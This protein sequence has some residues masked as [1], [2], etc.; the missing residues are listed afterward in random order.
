MSN[1]D[2]SPYRLAFQDFDRARRERFFEA[3]DYLNGL[4]LAATKGRESYRRFNEEA[5]DQGFAPA[6]QAFTAQ[7]WSLATR[8][9]EAD[10]ED[11][12]T[13]RTLLDEAPMARA[14]WLT[15]VETAVSLLAHGILAPEKAREIWALLAILD[16]RDIH[17]RIDAATNDL[18]RA[19][20]NV[21][22]P[23]AAGDDRTLIAETAALSGDAGRDYFERFVP[24]D[25]GRHP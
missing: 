7:A 15:I 19:C 5:G 20:R 16:H 6:W 14:E 2:V 21:G 11:R 17:R 4:R 23:G 18:I 22:S 1:L 3:R 13:V 12:A 10:P 24:R 8:Y 25:A 9:R